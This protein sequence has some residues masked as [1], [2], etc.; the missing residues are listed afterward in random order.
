MAHAFMLEKDSPLIPIAGLGAVSRIAH[1][2]V[3]PTTATAITNR[4]DM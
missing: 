2:T 3:L 4:M 1:R